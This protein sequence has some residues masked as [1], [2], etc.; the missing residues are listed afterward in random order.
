[1]H[2]TS[3]EGVRMI[4]LRYKFANDVSKVI[5]AA[6][7]PSVSKVQICQVVSLQALADLSFVRVT[8]SGLSVRC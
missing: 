3:I 2:G 6:Y 5:A 7:L 1:M 4:V 8:D